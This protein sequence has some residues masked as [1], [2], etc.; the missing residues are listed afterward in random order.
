M[1]GGCFEQQPFVGADSDTQD[2]GGYG[3]G[4][5]I[6]SQWMYDNSIHHRN[7]QLSLSRCGFTRLMAG[8]ATT[9]CLRARPSLTTVGHPFKQS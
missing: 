8:M 6:T 4:H 7:W 5:D 3:R 1:T 9:D 2:C